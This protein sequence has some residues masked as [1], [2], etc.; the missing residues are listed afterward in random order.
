MMMR[1]SKRVPALALGLLLTSCSTIGFH[2][3]SSEQSG[4][5]SPGWTDSVLASM[6]LRE[7]AAQI[8]WPSL[9]GDY[10]SGDSPQWRRLSQY[11]QQ[12]KVGGFTISVGSP[13]EVAAKLNA[14]QAMSKIPLLF[15]ADLEAGAGFRARGGYFVPNAIDLG[16]AIVFPPEMA[17]GASETPRS[18][19]NRD[20]SPHSKGARSGYTSRTPRCS[21]SITIR[22]IPSSTR[23]P[24]ARILS[25]PPE[26][27][28]HSFT[29]CR[30]T[31]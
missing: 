3:G 17:I 11:I 8:V 26:W 6:T 13:I 7:K 30:I 25:S 2:S 14:L 15:G 10:V 24:T 9:Y 5:T 21:T 16:G 12:D 22:T 28:S 1:K 29:A 4:T 18:L 31:A 19:T 23:A 27:E 20:V